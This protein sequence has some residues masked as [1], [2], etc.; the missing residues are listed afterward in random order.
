VF[1]YFKGFIMKHPFKKTIVL[2]NTTDNIKNALQKGVN[3]SKQHNTILEILFVHE[4][5]LFELPD[6]FRLKREENSLD[7]ESIKK[8]I[9]RQLLELN[10]NDK[11]AIFVYIDDTLHRLKSIAKEPKETVVITPYHKD[12]T[13][14]LI[15]ETSY[16]FWVLKETKESYKKILLPTD[17]K[18]PTMKA[19]NYALHIFQGSKL[20]LVHDHRYLVDTLLVQADYL[21][22]API[23]SP[24]TFELNEEIKEAH[25]KEFENYLKE[26]GIDG[27]FIEANGEVSEDLIEYTKQHEFD[28]LFM[29]RSDEELFS[30]ASLIVTLMENLEIDFFI[31]F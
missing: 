30:S 24:L 29:Y 11:Y 25:Q 17:L 7:K 16:A 5:P 9:N 15:E 28:L 12:I 6:I 31:A 26:F 14:T 1:K 8:E 21:N 3:F 22:V 18:E 4:E 27:E 19:I 13:P 20:F 2:L 23:T 10:P